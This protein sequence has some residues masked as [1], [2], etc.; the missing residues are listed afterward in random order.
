MSPPRVER[1]RLALQAAFSPQFLD[2]EDQSHLHAGH[3]GAA[4]G[5]GHFHVRIVAE[6]FD[7]LPLIRRH[8]AVYA[9]VG[10]LMQTDIHALSMETRTPAEAASSAG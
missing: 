2:V 10:D 1:I 7:G 8:R 5:R 6:A 3:A 9:A 4:T